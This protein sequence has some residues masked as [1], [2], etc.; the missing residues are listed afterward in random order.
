MVPMAP[1]MPGIEVGPPWSPTADSEWGDG[2]GQG[3]RRDRHKPAALALKS[4]AVPV[5]RERVDEKA[6]Q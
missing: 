1:E 2:G 3:G 6:Q 5:M 4:G